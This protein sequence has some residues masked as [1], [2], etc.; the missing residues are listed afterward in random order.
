MHLGA[1]VSRTNRTRGINHRG[2]IR[3]VVNFLQGVRARAGFNILAEYYGARYSVGIC[4]LRRRASENSFSRNIPPDTP[5]SCATAVVPSLSLSLFG[6]LV[7][8]PT[9][10]GNG[11]PE[12]ARGQ[13]R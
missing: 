5:A 12:Y 13:V 7:G 8:R 1:R 4:R 2:E 10:R 9:R 11:V 3:G 6:R